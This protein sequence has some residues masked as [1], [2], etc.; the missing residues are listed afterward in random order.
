M[1]IKIAR[2]RRNFESCLNVNL[3]IRAGHI[4]LLDSKRL[5]WAQQY[6]RRERRMATFHHN[7]RCSN[8]LKGLWHSVIQRYPVSS[9]G[10]CTRTQAHTLMHACHIHVHPIQVPTQ[11]KQVHFPNNRNIVLSIIVTFKDTYPNVF[12]LN[13]TDYREHFFF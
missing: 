13:M 7:S 11:N 9:C 10:L 4:A 3:Y 5:L 1:V 8:L 2:Q 6:H 12:T